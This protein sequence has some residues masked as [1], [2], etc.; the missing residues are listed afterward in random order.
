M[1]MIGAFFDFDKTLLETESAKLGFQ[2]LWER[3]MISFGFLLKILIANFFY[4]R[5]LVSDEFMGGI[6]L[7]FYQGKKLEEFAK[8]APLFY[9]Q[10]LRPR[11]APNILSKVREHQK[12]GHVLILISGSV[13]YLLEP[14][15]EDIG[16]DHLLCTDL[17]VGTDGLLT[18]QSNGPFCINKTKRTLA[19]H[20]AQKQ[21]I[22]LSR[23]F[24]YGN[25]Q[26]DIPLLEMV[27]YPFAVE[28]TEPLKKV[29]FKRNWPILGFK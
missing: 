24:A 23:S 4:Q 13:R 19:A 2:Y 10:Y 11:L 14:V 17:E 26:S 27:G 20:L 1:G 5:H 29:A 18:G 22:D 25:H 28:P 6:I 3:R 15:I 16:F 12:K 21:G 7:K 8:G 9:R